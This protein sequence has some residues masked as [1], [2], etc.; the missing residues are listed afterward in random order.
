MNIRPVTSEYF[1]T[2]GAV[3]SGY[4]VSGLLKTLDEK[5]PKPGKGTVY[6]ASCSD[7]EK[8][9]IT[10]ELEANAYGGLPIE[11]GYCNGNNHVLNCLEYHRGSE[12]NIPSQDV[13]LLLAD[14]RKMKDNTIDT[15]EIEAF[16]VP[17]GTVVQLYETTLHYAPCTAPGQEGFRVVIVLL[18]G[19]NTQKE[20]IVVKSDEDKLLFARNKWLVAHKDSPEA[21]RGAFVGLH[22][23]NLTV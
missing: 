18:K 15:Q 6:V 3:I 5:T 10:K 9:L 2:Y 14:K 16:L 11:V 17:A 21:K 1:N 19:T 20:D 12:L 22:G 4:D 8:V 23:I 13:I 7:L